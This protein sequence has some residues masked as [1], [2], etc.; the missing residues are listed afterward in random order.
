LP[1]A[2]DNIFFAAGMDK[3]LIVLPDRNLIQRWSLTTFERE[4]TVPLPT[5]ERVTGVAMG[6][7]SDG[8]LV[9]AASRLRLVDVRTMREVTPEASVIG[10][11]HPQY[12]PALRISPDGQVLGKW[13]PGLSPS[14]LETVTINGRTLER[15]YEH[16]TVGHIIPGPGGRYLFTGSGLY[17]SQLKRADGGAPRTAGGYLVPD[18]RGN[19]YLSVTN[20]AGVPGRGP[21]QASVAVHL[22]GETRPLLT[23]ND[24]DGLEGQ[25]APWRPTGGP[26]PLEKRLYPIPLGKVIVSLPVTADKLFLYRFDLDQALEKSDIDY[27]LVTSQPRSTAV[28][29]QAYS[30]ALA[31]KS[32][33]GGVKCRLESGP[34]GMKITPDGKLTW[35]VPAGFPDREVDVIVT[36]SDASGQEIFHTFKVVVNPKAD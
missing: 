30:Y 29:G 17:T 1:V 16:T 20:A 13:T 25:D 21:G 2:D 23:L 22:T 34:S 5:A 12:P 27:L 26:L 9:L 19:L 8:P 18:Q 15:R 7:A 24:L 4:L 31:V 32:R 14:G 6:S 28:K 3:L 35:D 10:P 11:T 33:K 36:V